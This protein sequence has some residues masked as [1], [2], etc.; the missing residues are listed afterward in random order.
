MQLGITVLG[1]RNDQIIIEI[2]SAVSAC[3]CSILELRTANLTR[4]V[5]A[6]MLVEGSWNRIAK[7]ENLLETIKVRNEIELC[8]LRPA[9]GESELLSSNDE[10]VPYSLE[11]IS[12]EKQDLLYA[13]SSFLTE[14]GIIIEEIAANRY[15][16]MFFNNTV[17][18]S[19]FILM[20][21]AEV[22]ILSFREEFL[23]FCDNLNIDAIFEPIKR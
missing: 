2:L 14:H 15:Q 20:V 12:M 13:I 23:D 8:L 22:K 1:N 6:H 4:L 5:S 17:F 3:Q 18:S 10:G 21:P 19:K 7:L 16:A 11:T 9:D